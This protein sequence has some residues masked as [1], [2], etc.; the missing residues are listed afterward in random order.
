MK[1][2]K[3]SVLEIISDSR[4]SEYP[5][6]TFL[7]EENNALLSNT[8]SFCNLRLLKYTVN[9]QNT[10]EYVFYSMYPSDTRKLIEILRNNKSRRFKPAC[11]K[12]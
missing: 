11:I 1:Q 6:F 5:F 3:K 4:L 12:C 10:C 2:K 9:T 8:T 7:I